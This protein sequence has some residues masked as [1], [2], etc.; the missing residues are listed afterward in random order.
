MADPVVFP[1]P[2]RFTG[3]PSDLAAVIEWL[4]Q[5]YN[6]AVPAE[7]FLQTGSLSAELQ[8]Q[9]PTLYNLGVLQPLAADGLPFITSAAGE[10]G[11]ASLTPFSRTALSGSDQAAWQTA[12]GIAGVVTDAE[13]LALAAL[14]SAADRMPYFTG[15]GTAALA[16]FTA[17]GRALV[18]DA[19]AADQR[20]TLALGAAAV[21]TYA[22]GTWTPAW[23]GLVEAGGGA[24]TFTGSYTRIGRLVKWRSTV[25]SAGGRTSAST[26]GVSYH[27]LPI[28]AA[29]DDTVTAAD[30]TTNTGLGT[31]SLDSTNDR[32]YSPAWAATADTIVMSG[33]YEA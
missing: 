13:L 2:P 14:V 23:T 22:T 6:A 19:T 17:Q 12:L 28:A 32:A 29:G 3:R 1:S 30:R 8:A 31:G 11:F 24:L 18:D 5:F 33:S 25:S 7:G 26:G 10:W 16:V 4:W 9:F 21:E 27:D 20:T 15:L